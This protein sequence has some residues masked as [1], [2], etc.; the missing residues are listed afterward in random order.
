[1]RMNTTLLS[2]VALASQLLLNAPAQAQSAE[3]PAKPASGNGLSDSD[4]A[5]RDADKVLQWI[6]FVASKPAA[7]PEPAAAPAPASPP[8]SHVAAKASIAPKA[9][10]ATATQAPPPVAANTVTERATE[11]AV[12]VPADAAASVAS[13]QAEPA[14]APAG[15]DRQMLAAAPAAVPQ[16]P[17]TDPVPA[18]PPKPAEDEPLRLISK[19]EP[20]MPRQMLNG[21]RDGTVLVRFIVRPDGSVGEA[22]AIKA[23]N[24]RLAGSALAAVRQWK[25]AP[26]AQ[27]REATVEIGFRTE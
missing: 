19:V 22:E 21:F 20:E 3:A 1:M 4:R 11:T 9:A 15:F 2:L 12:A 6:K 14:P 7:K 26:L 13:A 17:R 24:K 25:F 10:A 8:V 16:T 18:A 5:K 27:A 23:T